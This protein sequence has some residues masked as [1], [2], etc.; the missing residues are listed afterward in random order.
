VNLQSSKDSHSSRETN[1][2]SFLDITPR[3][4]I[5]EHLPVASKT[6]QLRATPAGR[7]QPPTHR[8]LRAQGTGVGRGEGGN[9]FRLVPRLRSEW[10]S[11]WMVRKASCS[12]ACLLSN[13]LGVHSSDGGTHR[14][15][16]GQRWARKSAPPKTVVP[17]H[18]RPVHVFVL[19]PP[20]VR[21]ALE[22]PIS[23]IFPSHAI[24]STAPSPRSAREARQELCKYLEAGWKKLRL[25]HGNTSVQVRSRR[26]Q[27]RPV[28][29]RPHFG[30]L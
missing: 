24:R 20:S 4:R 27:S 22:L 14:P 10:L 16:D 5:Q 8:L 11:G 13:A 19:F 2:R 17:Q 3:C 28:P 1:P 23:T 9:N 30:Q 26:R 29:D 25:A 15:A 12:L 6:L 7:L 18:D 21:V